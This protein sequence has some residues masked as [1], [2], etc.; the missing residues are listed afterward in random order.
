MPVTG[1]FY[2][3]QLLICERVNPDPQTDEP[4]SPA[5]TP[6]VDCRAWVWGPVNAPD[7]D[8]CLCSYCA[9]HGRPQR[10]R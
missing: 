6:C 7:Y 3:E 9:V 8:G 1:P 4:P 2:T 5:W 10:R